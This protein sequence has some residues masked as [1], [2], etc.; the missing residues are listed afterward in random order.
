MNT[1]TSG[2]K[3]SCRLIKLVS[4]RMNFHINFHIIHTLL[5][6]EWG[7]AGVHN[8]PIVKVS[9]VENVVRAQYWD[10]REKGPIIR[11]IAP[12]SSVIIG[13]LRTRKPVHY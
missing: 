7:Q 1:R 2:H 3:S 13:Q 5:V 12:Q 6:G 11:K 4:S 8:A 9:A 10:C